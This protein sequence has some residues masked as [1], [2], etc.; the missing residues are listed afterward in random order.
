MR[1]HKGLRRASS[2]IPCP[3]PKT[4]LP[5]TR[6]SKSPMPGALSVNFRPSTLHPGKSGGRGGGHA[7]KPANPPDQPSPPVDWPTHGARKRQQ[8]AAA[9][10]QPSKAAS[11]RYSSQGALNSDPVIRLACRFVQCTSREWT[12]SALSR[13]GRRLAHS[14]GKEATQQAA[15]AKQQARQQAADT[16]AK[17]L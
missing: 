16:A 8:A 17:A 15:T 4:Q 14:R 13:L 1:A 10:H 2:R 7:D 9:K 5:V 12:A 11:S 6:T 3:F